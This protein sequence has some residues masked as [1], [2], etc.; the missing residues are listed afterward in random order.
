VILKA[1]GWYESS[2]S[3]RG[4]WT[5][6]VN[7]VPYT[8]TDGCA[9]GLMQIR[10]GMNCDAP[11]NQFNAET[12]QRVKYDYRYNI[13]MGAFMLKRWKW[14]EHQTAGHIIGD[15]DPR[16]AEHWYYAVWAYNEW[17]FKNS[18]NNTARNPCSNWPISPVGC[19]YQDT[20]W[21]W[22]AHPPTRGGRTLWAPVN[23]TCP[24]KSLFPRYS[25]QW[26]SW[27]WRI[28]DPLPVHQDWC[29]NCLPLVLKNYPPCARPIQNGN[30][31]ARSAYW[32]LGGLTIIS[33]NR[34]HG[35]SY[36]AWLGGY[37][38]ANDTLYQTIT[39][40]STGPTGR[41]V[42]SAR[43]TYY[44]Y[45]TTEETSPS[46]DFD[47]LY[48][49]IRGSP[50]RTVET[51]TNRSVKDTWAFS[52][53]DVSEFI[54]QTVQV[55]FRATTEATLPTSFFVDDVGLYACEGG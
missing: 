5:Q 15:G 44:W 32:T 29:R 27:N 45:M 21:W 31:E 40:P 25:W 53:F 2:D 42:V 35:G 51:L 22:A 38:N 20:V 54:G 3:P 19:A 13:A 55:Y 14:D 12:Q 39:I 36:S 6:C 1:I 23:L 11:A 9:W 41:P 17:S 8:S 34:P 7:G 16:I 50:I 4:G 47:Y 46:T 52:S 48:V 49:Q 26:D 24:D 30:F 33:L 10:S 28:A 43:L 37:D 18:P